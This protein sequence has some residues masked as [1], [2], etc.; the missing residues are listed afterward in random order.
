MLYKWGLSLDWNTKIVSGFLRIYQSVEIN[1]LD[2]A[3]ASTLKSEQK[4]HIKSLLKFTHRD[5][6]V[7]IKTCQRYTM[8]EA[9]TTFTNQLHT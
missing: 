4:Q 6:I 8:S 1:S 7:Q 9:V 5:F 3:K 2:K